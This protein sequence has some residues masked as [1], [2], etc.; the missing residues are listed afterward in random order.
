ML[1]PSDVDNSPLLTLLVDEEL[2]CLLAILSG[3]QEEGP[4]E[5]NALG[6]SDEGK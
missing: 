1:A 3:A 5:V 6:R 2:E 4:V